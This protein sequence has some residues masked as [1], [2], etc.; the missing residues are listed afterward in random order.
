MWDR[1]V[2]EPFLTTS[3]V[4]GDTECPFCLKGGLKKFDFY[5]TYQ[6]EIVEGPLFVV[7]HAGVFSR[8]THSETSV[9]VVSLCFR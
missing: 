4:L 8:V 2:R 7:D 5:W 9:H 3:R 1:R 6:T